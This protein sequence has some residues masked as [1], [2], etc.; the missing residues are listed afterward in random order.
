MRRMDEW[1]RRAQEFPKTNELFSR[2]VAENQE[3]LW[4]SARKGNAKAI[5]TLISKL[6]ADPTKARPNGTT[7]THVAA[8]YGKGVGFDSRSEA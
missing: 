1:Q 4:E 7:L 3:R 5:R 6:N 2:N 8:H